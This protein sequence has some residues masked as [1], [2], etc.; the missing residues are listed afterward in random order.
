MDNLNYRNNFPIN[1]N[2]H[3]DKE[4]LFFNKWEMYKLLTPYKLPF[5]IP[6]TNFLSR[7]SIDLFTTRQ[8]SFYIKPV[9]TW[10]GKHI[11]LITPFDKGYII[12]QPNGADE[13]HPNKE[14]LIQVLVHHY[15]RM[16]AI[17]QQ[18]APLLPFDSRAFDIRVHLQRDENGFWLYAG[19]LIRIGG[20]KAIVSNLFTKGGGVVETDF[21]LNKVLDSYQV[22]LVKENL[23]KSAFSIANLLDYYYYFIDIGADFGI[24][25]KGNL[26]LLEVNTNDKVGKPAYD[27]FKKLPDKTVYKQMIAKDKKRKKI[28]SRDRGTGTL[29]QNRI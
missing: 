27:L 23:A 6:Y 25:Q 29:S 9:D 13:F 3:F 14:A 26:W 15:S 8:I 18:R 24:D 10:A 5:H 17:I 11:S 28:W 7:Q 1:T 4:R 12:Q 22:N 19:D 20:E 21:V 16:H 2:V